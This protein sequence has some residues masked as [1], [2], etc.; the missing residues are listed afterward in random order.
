MATD[1]TSKTIK[2]KDNRTLGYAEYGNKEDKP[3]F[4]FHGFPGSR[5]DW[6]YF[7]EKLLVVE[8][9][10]IRVIAPDRPG[11]GLSNFQRGR[12]ILDWPDDVV[13]LADALKLDRFAILGI[14]GGGPYACACAYKIPE[15]LTKTGIISGMGPAEAPGIK[16]GTA[17]TFSGKNPVMRRLMLA[18]TAMGMRK[19]P[20]RIKSQMV[21]G[22]K[23]PD[24]E[25]ILKNP[26]FA[27]I[28]IKT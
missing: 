3:L 15:R 19:Q 26:R 5:L 8:E 17:W 2:L 6:N 23:G 20:D 1:N 18:L 21:D 16:D 13:E 4:C 28:V 12:N 22:L 7:D 25:L 9:L 24:K 27:E 11:M 10:N 14:S